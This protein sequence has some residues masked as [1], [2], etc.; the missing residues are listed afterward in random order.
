MTGF[1]RRLRAAEDRLAA[2]SP[3]QPEPRPWERWLGVL[4]VVLPALV[5]AEPSDESVAAVARVRHSVALL[6]EYGA[7]DA[8]TDPWQYLEYY[9]HQCVLAMSWPNHPPPFL[10][11]GYDQHLAQIVEIERN[12]RGPPRVWPD[13]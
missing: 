9:C 3:R 4:R 5:R 12:R 11:P 10:D 8:Q 1:R 13:G 2:A 6:E 7:K